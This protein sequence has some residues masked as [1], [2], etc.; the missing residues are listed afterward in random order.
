MLSLSVQQIITHY[1]LLPHPEGGYYKETYRSS[2]TIAKNALPERFTGV[3]HFSTAIYFLLEKNTFSAFHK[4]KSDECWHFYSG[5]TLL[6]YIIDTKGILTT[7]RL[8]NNIP[9]GDTFQY[10]V[11][12]ECWFAAEPAPG[13]NFSLVGCT[14]APGFDFN[15]FEL[16]KADILMK[17]YPQYEAYIRKFCRR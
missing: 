14:V 12:A 8:G 1:Q 4:I 3:R 2:E 6:I 11:P 13:S 10:V 5:Q 9:M 16:A 15:D 17:M 7:V